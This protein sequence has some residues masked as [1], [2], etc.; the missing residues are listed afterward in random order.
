MR[1]Q[2]DAW[3][4]RADRARY[5]T[6]RDRERELGLRPRASARLNLAALQAALVRA[7][8]GLRPLPADR[9]VITHA[10]ALAERT[11]RR[12]EGGS[13]DGRP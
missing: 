3:R 10:L 1:P 4:V 12:M 11:L 9:A 8:H 6:L 7:E 13:R 5:A 2:V